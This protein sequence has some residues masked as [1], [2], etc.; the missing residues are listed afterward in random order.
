M[1]FD[2]QTVDALV[3]AIVRFERAEASRAFDPT[4]LRARAET[5]DRPRFAARMAE[6]VERRWHEHASRAK[7]VGATC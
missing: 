2:A 1:F 4:V 7:M 3:G 6:Y 5:F